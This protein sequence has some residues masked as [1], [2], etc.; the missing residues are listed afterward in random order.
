MLSE[1]SQLVETKLCFRC[2]NTKPI[3]EFY[4]HRKRN[5]PQC[6]CKMCCVVVS[7]AC[8]KKKPLVV[9]Y[10]QAKIRDKKKGFLSCSKTEWLIVLNSAS[11]CSYC[12]VSG[13]LGLDRIDNSA[14][15]TVGN[16][17]PCCYSCNVTRGDRF[18]YSE[19][20]SILAPALRKVQDLRQ[21]SQK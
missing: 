2:K 12:G 3:S 6:Y 4:W 17:V 8:N 14:G 1:P 13:P 20:I 21:A 11:E 9:K 19:M 7:S 18:S 16:M 15:H 10:A 5:E